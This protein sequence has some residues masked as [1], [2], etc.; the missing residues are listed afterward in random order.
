MFNDK[1]LYKTKMFFPATTKNLNW[2]TLT[3]NSVTFKDWDGVSRVF[4]NS[5]KGWGIRNF[6]MGGRGG[7]F[8]PGEGSLRSDL[9][10]LN[11]KAKS[12]FL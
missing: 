1:K 6:T 12:S 7:I 8:L 10:K 11:L 9:G 2:E 3:K 5:S 4:P